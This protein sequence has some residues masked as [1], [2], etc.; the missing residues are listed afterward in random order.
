M[1]ATTVIGDL[2]SSRDIDDRPRLQPLIERALSEANDVI[3]AVQPLAFTIGDEFQGA[4][5]SLPEAIRATT[6]VRLSLPAGLDCR[7]GIGHGRI[8]R[9]GEG[10]WMPIQDGPG[11]W[12]ARDAITE[13][14]RLEDK[15][16]PST[17][18]WFVAEDSG[19][20][21]QDPGLV[22][23]YLLLRDHLIG[24]MNDREQHIALG[25]MHGRNQQALAS[26]LGISQSAVSQASQ[27]SGVPALLAGL[28]A[29]TSGLAKPSESTRT[30]A[31]ASNMKERTA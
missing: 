5:R 7:F 29:L 15:R 26:E 17:R 20:A 21:S 4:Y 31:L 23:A 14:H 13:A 12:T 24:R 22:N 1:L 28:T 30:A 27:R 11:W 2:V 10:T 18:S 19:E 25:T 6:L 16:I 9:V 3:D 8:E